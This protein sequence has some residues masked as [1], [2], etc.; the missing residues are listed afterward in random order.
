M[1]ANERYLEAFDVAAAAFRRP[2]FVPAHNVEPATAVY[3]IV[4]AGLSIA[5][6]A[7]LTG[8]SRAEVAKMC[9][10]VRRRCVVDRAFDAT[11]ACLV[12][13]FAAKL[14]QQARAH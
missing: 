4:G 3:L 9:D 14:E 8:W 2:G 5:G 10:A 12:R 13:A 6:T 11:I 1:R 7:D